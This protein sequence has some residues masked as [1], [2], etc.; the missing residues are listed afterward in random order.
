MNIC[1]V[2]GTANNELESQCRICG[3]TLSKE[4][5]SQAAPVAVQNAPLQADPVLEAA[6]PEPAPPAAAAEP[7]PQLQMSSV[8]QA[9]PTGAPPMLGNAAPDEATAPEPEPEWDLPS[10]MQ[11]GGRQGFASA[12]DSANLISANDLPDWIRQIAEADAAKAEAEAMEQ[13]A[14]AAEPSE[15]PASIVKR[16]LPGETK[17]SAPTSTTWLSKSAAPQESGD[18]WAADEVEAAGWTSAQTAPQP[19]VSP[20][21]YPT[22]APHT[23]FV[24]AARE[25]TADSTKRGRFSLPSSSAPSDVP[26]YRSLPVQLAF[27]AVLLMVLLAFVL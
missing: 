24:P 4:S 9:A 22:I 17:V 27:V 25:S 20:P 2:C 12:Q 13:A 7:Q 11:Q 15:A 10:F 8:R 3:H 26:F 23:S 18:A 5:Q 1:E 14:R 6:R 21:A 16:A 19:H